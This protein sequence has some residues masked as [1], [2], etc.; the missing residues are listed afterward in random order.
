M[1]EESI[2]RGKMGE[3]LKKAGR[4]KVEKRSNHGKK[5]KAKIGAVAAKAEIGATV[6]MAAKAEIGA[7]AAMAAKKAE[8]GAIAKNSGQARA[9]RAATGREARKA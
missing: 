2:K 4:K 1:K 6:A 3:C 8:I 7:M 9:A 5:Q